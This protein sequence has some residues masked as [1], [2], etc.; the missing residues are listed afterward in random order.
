MTDLICL[1][2]L[3]YISGTQKMKIAT[4]FWLSFCL[5]LSQNFSLSLKTDHYGG[6]LCPELC[7]CI[8][9]ETEILQ[10]QLHCRRVGLR[11]VPA[12]EAAASVYT[13][14][15]SYNKIEVLDSE[16]LK[17][18]NSLSTLLLND[19]KLKQI[20]QDAFH[21]LKLWNLPTCLII[22]WLMC[23]MTCSHRTQNSR[24]CH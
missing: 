20:D 22:S 5:L 12:F 14:D 11:Q 1:Y 2:C 24:S 7:S 23:V 10:L 18:Y 21:S 15:I 9:E 16:C 4:T 8:V 17:L 3:L 6:R 13:L 19:T